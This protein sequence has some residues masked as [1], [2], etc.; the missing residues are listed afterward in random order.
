MTVE[1]IKIVDTLKNIIGSDLGIYKLNEDVWDAVAILPDDLMG[2]EYPP[3]GTSVEGI[4]IVVV[5]P[6]AEILNTLDND[7]IIRNRW[8]ITIKQ[9]DVTRNLVDLVGRISDLMEIYLITSIKVI[10]PDEQKGIVESINFDVLE[11]YL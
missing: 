2:W 5:R 7:R 8:K 10:P 1:T 6:Y 11:Y 3:S 9:W 4:E